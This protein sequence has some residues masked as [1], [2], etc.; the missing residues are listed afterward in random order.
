MFYMNSYLFKILIIVSIL[1]F[2][3]SLCAQTVN[4]TFNVDMQ[5]E[6]V[7]ENGVHLAGSFQQ[8]NSSS[9]Q[10]I[11]L[12]GDGVYSVTLVLSSDSIYEYKYINGNSWGSD[13]D[14]T[15]NCGAGNGNRILYVDTNDQY[16]APFYFNTCI[17]S[18][19][20]CMDII[21]NNYDS[22]VLSDDGSCTY[23]IS[24]QFNV[25]MYN[26]V[27]SN[28]GI[29]IS[30]SFN[31]WISDS[32]EMFDND[33]DGIYSVLIDL[34]QGWYYEYKFINGNTWG[35]DEY[36]DATVPAAN[37]TKED[38]GRYIVISII[39]IRI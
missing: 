8:W 33:G 37:F 1:F 5:N 20:G 27:V 2:Y 36:L 38:P 18:H 14:I 11:D 39:I 28:N 16:L 26:E 21:A 9:T 22:T 15:G 25:N 7:S 23:T 31:N 10:M 12:D 24:V 32:I 17:N 4:I 35:A 3:V 34:N 29:Y 19:T 6:T 30:G 13:E